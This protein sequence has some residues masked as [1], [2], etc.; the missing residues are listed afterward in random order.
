[1]KISVIIPAYNCAKYIPSALEC[2]R[3]QTFPQNQL[4]IV[5]YLDGCTDKTS[6]EISKFIAI[7][8]QMNIRVIECEQ[9]MGVSHARNMAVESARG[10]YIH[11]FDPDDLINS[12]FYSAMYSAASGANADVVVASFI[13]ERWPNDSI[14]FQYKNTLTLPQDKLSHTCVDLHGYSCRYLIRWRYWTANKFRFPTNMRYCEDILVMLSMVHFSNF[15]V[16]VPD[17]VYTYKYRQ[18]SALTTNNSIVN[19]RRESDFLAARESVERFIV[20]AK[21]SASRQKY[22]CCKYR[23]FGF[24]PFIFSRDSLCGTRTHFY[25]FRFL[26]ILSLRRVTRHTTFRP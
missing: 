13:N 8:P 21:L 26:P 24:I 9:N 19:T 3:T 1:M 22:R 11:F 25:L 14:V 12:D 15:I 4:E 20:N 7:Y 5:I 2:I 6:R 16:T 23:L 18:N 10:E 17:A